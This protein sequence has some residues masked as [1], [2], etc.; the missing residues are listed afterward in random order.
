MSDVRY[1]MLYQINTRVWLT[2]LSSALGR[3]ATLDDIPD[4]ELD[5]IAAMRLRL[6]LV[7]ERLADRPGGAGDLACA[8]RMAP[9]VRRY[10]AGSHG[11][12]HR[13]LRVRH[14]ELHG[15]SRSGRRRGARPLATAAA[16]TRTEADARLRA[17]SHGAGSRLDRRASGL[18][19]PRQRGGPGSLAAQ[20]LPGADKE[21]P[22]GVR[23]RPGPRTST[24]GPTRCSSTTAIR[25]CSR[26]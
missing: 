9:R 16:A 19:C 23:L 17:E 18:L 3:R 8:C 26:R 24:A 4:A 25:P 7:A 2:E 22:A 14:P 21:W 12:R 11:R 10:A 15:P 5:R 1:P 6:G 20:L 13:R